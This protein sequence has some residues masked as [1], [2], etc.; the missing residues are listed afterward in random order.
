MSI[1]Q[2]P[3]PIVA[4]AL[5]HLIAALTELYDQGYTTGHNGVAIS[6][7]NGVHEVEIWLDKSSATYYYEVDAP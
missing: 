3:D 2:H 4:D 6:S 1:N 7:T 5:N